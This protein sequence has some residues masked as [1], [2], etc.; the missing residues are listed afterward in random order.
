MQS[1]EQ[2]L[3]VIV[4][5]PFLIDLGLERTFLLLLHLLE[6]SRNLHIVVLVALYQL[7]NGL[8]FSGP[9]YLPGLVSDVTGPHLGHLGVLLWMHWEDLLAQCV[10]MLNAEVLCKGSMLI[11]IHQST[12]TD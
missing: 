3:N 2:V 1:L 5:P 12:L 7:F 10:T 11:Y 8:L 6:D 9:S 4:S